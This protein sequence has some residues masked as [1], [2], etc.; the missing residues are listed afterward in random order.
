[1]D[2]IDVCRLCLSENV[3]MYDI[4]DY[5]SEDTTYSEFARQI[6]NLQETSTA[7]SEA[8]RFICVNCSEFCQEILKFR[9]LII[10]SNEHLLERENEVKVEDDLDL[11]NYIIEEEIIEESLIDSD[12]YNPPS[13]TESLNVQKPQEK[14]PKQPKRKYQKK[15]TFECEICQKNFISE[16]LLERHDV[17]HSNMFEQME[18]N[19]E[20]INRC[21]VCNEKFESEAQLNSHIKEHKKTMKTELTID[22]Q[23]CEKS[24]CN[25]SSL[26]RHL[27]THEENK[28]LKCTECDKKFA[29]GSQ[30]LIDHLNMHKG[31][32]PNVCDVCGKSFMRRNRLLTH[33]K[34]HQM[35]TEQEQPVRFH[36]TLKFTMTHFQF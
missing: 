26:I 12:H 32:A 35:E 3:D 10:S 5:I 11:K 21:L 7:I 28:T 36:S 15:G 22:C 6:I 2:E 18:D 9:F 29:P 16:S 33:Q 1:M 24:H 17:L 20:D 27:N 4:N 14:S 13:D 25:Y 30:E 23:Y 8:S 34:T 31:F 19:I